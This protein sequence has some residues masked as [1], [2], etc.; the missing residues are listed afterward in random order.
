M[1]SLP[2]C[3]MLR[4]QSVWFSLVEKFP[5]LLTGQKLDFVTSLKDVWKF[6]FCQTLE[7][8]LGKKFEFN[9]SPFQITI[10]VLYK[11]ETSECNCL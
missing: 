3:L 6:L 1:V 11:D 5:Q 2:V 7:A 10:H 9:S 4:E 8:K